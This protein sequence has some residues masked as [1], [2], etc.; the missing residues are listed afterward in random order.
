MRGRK[1][2]VEIVTKWRL[3][4]CW[5]KKSGRFAC[6]LVF[7]IWRDTSW[8]FSL[9]LHITRYVLSVECLVTFAI[10][11]HDLLGHADLYHLHKKRGWFWWFKAKPRLFKTLSYGKKMTN[12]TFHA[13]RVHLSTCSVLSGATVWCVTIV[14]WS[15][16][17]LQPTYKIIGRSKVT[18][19]GAPPHLPYEER[20]IFFLSGRLVNVTWL[21]D[22]HPSFWN[23]VGH[24]LETA[25]CWFVIQTDR[26]NSSVQVCLAGSLHD[27]VTLL[28][29][30]N[31]YLHDGVSYL[32]SNIFSLFFFFFFFLK[33]KKKEIIK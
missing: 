26:L 19:E 21:P 22:I 1:Q 6:H 18:Q 14:W 4:S 10:T 17:S 3:R 13:P 29:V 5:K 24:R 12:L 9:F 23:N 25:V 8:P 2:Q 27:Y 28:Q 32:V 33:K 11:G 7:K 15:Y 30:H 20:V 16:W 31:S